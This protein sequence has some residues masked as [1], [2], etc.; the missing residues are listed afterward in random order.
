[1]ESFFKDPIKDYT[2]PIRSLGSW[3][4]K[5]E[6]EGKRDNIA[7]LIRTLAASQNPGKDFK[8]PQLNFFNSPEDE[9][10]EED[11]EDYEDPL[12][13]GSGGP[14]RPNTGFVQISSSGP[15]Q[16]R[17]ANG[18]PVVMT[19]SKG[20]VLL[21]RTGGPGGALKVHTIINVTNPAFNS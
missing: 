10:E 21:Q 7:T 19:P 5:D 18:S 11:D 8:Y 2:L 12:R 3:F 1:M 14:V 4:T 15:Q 16:V 9:S 13:G 20:K 6:V 17:V